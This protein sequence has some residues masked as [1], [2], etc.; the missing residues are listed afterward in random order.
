MRKWTTIMSPRSWRYLAGRIGGNVLKENNCACSLGVCKF[1]GEDHYIYF[2]L[3][4]E[5]LVLETQ[6]ENSGENLRHGKRR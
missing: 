1:S 4:Y 3:D 6:T 5:L 2:R